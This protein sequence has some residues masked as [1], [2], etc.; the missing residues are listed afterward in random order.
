MGEDRA[1]VICLF[2]FLFLFHL[3]VFFPFYYKPQT[4]LQIDQ[5]EKQTTTVSAWYKECDGTSPKEG[6]GSPGNAVPEGSPVPAP[7]AGQEVAGLETGSQ[8]GAA[9][10]LYPQAQSSA[11]VVVLNNLLF[12]RVAFSSL[13]ARRANPNFI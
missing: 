8:P 3:F 6:G 4:P 2:L 7:V 10:E 13:E 12:A 9:G 5:T 11:V 1:H